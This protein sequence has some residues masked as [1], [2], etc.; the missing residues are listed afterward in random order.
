MREKNDDSNIEK[1]NIGETIIAII[2]GT[3]FVILASI[4]LYLYLMNN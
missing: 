2:I 4:S 1:S 3:L